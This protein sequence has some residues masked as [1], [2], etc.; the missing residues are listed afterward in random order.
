MDEETAPELI[1]L[2]DGHQVVSVKLADRVPAWDPDYYAADIV[3]SSDFVNAR[4]RTLVTL[5]DLDHSSGALAASKQTSFGLPTGTHS[6]STAPRR[7]T[8]VVSASSRMIP[9]WWKSMT[10]PRPRS[11]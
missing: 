11:P 4:L 1:R 6:P 7:V 9:T 2:A 8:T 10:S 3:I 5:E